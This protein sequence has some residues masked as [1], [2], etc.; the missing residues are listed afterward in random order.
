MKLGDE[1]MQLGDGLSR[2][3]P[4]LVFLAVSATVSDMQAAV[5]MQVF[6]DRLTNFCM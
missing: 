6:I 3:C 1:L 5:S 2:V 4:L